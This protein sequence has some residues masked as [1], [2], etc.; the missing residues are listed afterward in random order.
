MLTNMR[1]AIHYSPFEPQVVPVSCPSQIIFA[2]NACLKNTQNV[3]AALAKP[4]LLQPSGV[5][6]GFPCGPLTHAECQ[7][8][9]KNEECLR[10]IRQNDGNLRKNEES[11]TH[12]HP[13][14]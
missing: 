13:G 5:A 7:F 12:A 9:D 4:S 6:R 10:K 2:L 1:L 14:L 3:H 11:G 8:E